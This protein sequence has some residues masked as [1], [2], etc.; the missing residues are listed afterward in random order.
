[1]EIVRLQ[2]GTPEWEAHRDQCHNASEASAMMG[3]HSKVKRRDL[4]EAKHFGL[5]KEFSR[6]V[7]EVLFE[8]GHEAEANERPEASERIADDLY[9][10]IG[11]VNAGLSRPLSASFDGLTLGWDICWEHKLWNEAKAELVRNNEIPPDDYWQC[12]QQM[13]ESGADRLLYTL[14]DG[15]NRDECWMERPS[16]DVFDKLIAGWKQFDEELQ[17]YVPEKKPDPEPVAQPV[18]GF[19]ALVLRVEGRVVNSNLD[20]FKAGAEAF[21]ARLPKPEELQT[22]QDFANADAA[23]KACKEAEAR[24]NGALEAAMGQMADI[25][26]LRRT[27]TSVGGTIREAR[28]ALNRLVEARKE[29]RK[30]EIQTGAR[31]KLEAHYHTLSESLSLRIHPPSSA[32]AE[33]SQAIKGLR[34]FANMEE[35]VDKALTQAK[36]AANEL[37]ER[38]RQCQGVMR[39]E[40]GDQHRGLFPDAKTLILEKAPEDLRNLAKARIAEAKTAEEQRIR[41]AEERAAAKAKAEAEAAK[42]PEPAAARPPAANATTAAVVPSADVPGAAECRDLPPL[43]L[44]QINE[45]I[46]P[47]SITQAGLAS[48]GIEPVGKERTA[49]L[50]AAEDFQRICQ[51]MVEIARTARINTQQQRKAA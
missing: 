43:K 30:L 4:L 50:Y 3:V 33:I 5:Q 23:V 51:A 11:T 48:L 39:E 28:L 22:D 38:I 41:E 27:V 42:Q 40:V 7:R 12:V 19:G 34:S 10:V 14:S 6:W 1:M 37:A 49:V 2:Q 9:P 16:Q 17:N 13:Y 44:G 35:A 8:R 31:E 32:R 25:D 26:E 24:I 36:L 47:L 46:A 20:Q 15:T 18:E 45:A 21:L 29:A